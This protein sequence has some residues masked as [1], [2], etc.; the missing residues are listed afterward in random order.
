MAG[1]ESARFVRRAGIAVTPELLEQLDADVRQLAHEYLRHPPYTMF[2]LLSARR[3]D[4]FELID[5]HPRPAYLPDLYHLAGQLSALLAHASSDLA[6]P[7]ASSGHARAAWLCADLSGDDALRAYVCWVQSQ[8]AYWQGDFTRAAELADA[9]QRFVNDGSNI[10]RLASQTARS[11]A[12][13]GDERGVNQA[14][15]VAA[16]A[17]DRALHE[18]KPAGVFY[19]A[20]GKAAYYASEARLSLAGDANARRAVLDAEEALALFAA[21]DD[22]CSPELIAAAQLDLASAHLALSNLGAVMEHLQ[23]VLALTAERRTMSIVQRMTKVR[24]ALTDTARTADLEERITLFCA[25]PAAHELP[26]G[27][28]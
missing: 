12:A 24:Q 11:R 7:Y 2:K 13:V 1:E 27:P 22:G 10:L 23:P 21:I 14:L 5:S 3:H 8:V 6:Q 9:G 16:E 17:R 26:P 19:F 20:P 25:Y 15:T 28:E 4:I 18:P